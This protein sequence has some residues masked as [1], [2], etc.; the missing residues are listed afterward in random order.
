[1]RLSCADGIVGFHKGFA[2]K[3][4]GCVAAAVLLVAGAALAA[5]APYSKPGLWTVNQA[6]AHSTVSTLFCIDSS[7]QKY[8]ADLGAKVGG[9]VCQRHD[10]SVKGSQ[11]VTDSVCKMGGSTLTSH[12]VLAFQG[13]SKFH[14]TV[15]GQFS[16]AMMGMSRTHAD[17]DGQWSGPC[18][19]GMKPGD[20]SSTMRGHTMKMHMGPNGPTPIR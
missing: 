20:M 3:L 9:E 15:D 5:P 13:D 4:T 14:E 1:L 16:P 10:V 18:P 8:L 6:T 2:M 11:V 7:T 19:A 12:A 17:V